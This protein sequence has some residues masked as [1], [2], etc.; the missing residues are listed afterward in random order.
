MPH[1]E[2]GLEWGESDPTGGRPNH[3]LFQAL[4]CFLLFKLRRP[5]VSKQTTRQLSK[6]R[7]KR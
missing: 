1:S 6:E 2:G 5:T 7:L 4:Y 3:K